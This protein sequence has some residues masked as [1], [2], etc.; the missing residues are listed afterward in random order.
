MNDKFRERA[1]KEFEKVLSRKGEW[2]GDIRR[3][4]SKSESRLFGQPENSSPSG[5]KRT[6]PSEISKRLSAVEKKT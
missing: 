5:E 3:I 2:I 6:Y 4:K 1:R